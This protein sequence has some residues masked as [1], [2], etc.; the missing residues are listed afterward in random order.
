M[1]FEEAKKGMRIICNVRGGAFDG[2]VKERPGVITGF[3]RDKTCAWV[4]L[5]GTKCPDV[6]HLDFLKPEEVASANQG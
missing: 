4:R 2:R 1:T 3:S 6:F 5:D